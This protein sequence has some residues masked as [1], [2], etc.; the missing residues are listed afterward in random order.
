M[1]DIEYCKKE[2]CESNPLNC[3]YYPS[4][5]KRDKIERM[6]SIIDRDGSLNRD[7]INAIKWLK[8]NGVK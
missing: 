2:R 7:K 8:E 4:Q 6:Q 3:G 5:C 1:I